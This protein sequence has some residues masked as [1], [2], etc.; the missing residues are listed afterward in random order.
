VTQA[1]ETR[2]IHH[3]RNFALNVGEGVCLRICLALVSSE[4]VLQALVQDLGA[5]KLLIGL[6]SGLFIPMWAF[7]QVL[8]ARLLGGRSKLKKFVVSFRLVAGL[9]W[10]V[11]SVYLLF[12]RP[13]WAGFSIVFTMLTLAF[14]ALFAGSLVP[15]WLEFITRTI[16]ATDLGKFYG[17]RTALGSGAALLAW[18]FVRWVLPTLPFP[19][20]YACCTGA[21]S[22][23]FFAGVL[24]LGMS[25]ESEVAHKPRGSSLNLFKEFTQDLRRDR[26]FRFLLFILVLA[27]FGGGAMAG[28]MSTAFYLAYARE[29]LVP[30]SVD[31]A[32]IE[33]VRNAYV[34]YA[35]IVYVL[36]QIIVGLLAG[37]LVDKLGARVVFFCGLLISVIVP[38]IALV[39]QSHLVYLAT[40]FVRG[41]A[42]AMA[43]CSYHT[44]VISIS[45]SDKAGRYLGMLNSF[46]AP[47]YLAAPIIGGTLIEATSYS[48]MFVVAAAMSFISVAAFTYALGLKRSGS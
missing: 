25:H 37:R 38:L 3:E 18:F 16:R 20:G 43:C 33:Y 35:G 42:F 14:F 7:F 47:F 17:W 9:F 11:F 48:T 31:S 24:L 28:S 10:A 39:I 44:L 41:A 32:H 6:T 12:S 46:R 23:V 4:L 30:A 27:A 45:P 26:Q 5:S 40:F 15:A 13:E 8:V 2:Y 22:L 34:G 1:T 29:V 21:A 36:A 19:Y